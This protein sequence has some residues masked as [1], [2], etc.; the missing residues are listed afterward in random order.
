MNILKRNIIC[1]FFI[2]TINSFAQINNSEITKEEISKHLH[3]LASEELEGRGTGTPG[4]ELAAKY[5]ANELNKYGFKPV[6]D[7]GYFQYFQVTTGVLLSKENY[8]RLIDDK[9]EKEAEVKVDYTPVGFSSNG[10]IEKE[11]VFVGFGI[12]T[13]TLN[14]NDYSKVD[15]KDK[16]VVIMTGNPDGKNG[17]GKFSEY[18]SL[19]YKTSN[20]RSFGAVGIIFVTIPDSSEE[21]NL[22]RLNYEQMGGQ[23]G[24]QIVSVKYKVIN[25][26]FKSFGYD[27]K[28]IKSKIISDKVPNSFELNKIKAS[29]SVN[30]EP[31]KKWGIN[32]VGLL[33]GND[34]KL[35]NEYI[36]IGAHY[37]HLGISM[38]NSLS[39]SQK[40]EIH[41]GADDN[42]SGT[43]SVIE[44][45]QK[46]SE[47]KEE[48]KRSVIISF[49][50]GEEMGVLGSTYLVNHPPVPISNIVSMLN[51][52][53]IG[54]LKEDSVLTINGVGSSSDWRM[55][56]TEVNKKYNFKISFVN[57]ASG[58]SDHATFYG[59]SIPVLFFFTGIHSDYHKPADKPELIN[60]SGAERVTNFAYDVFNTINL[61]SEKVVFT[62]VKEDTNANRRVSLRVTAGVIP[63]F[64]E[65][66]DG[67]KISGTTEGGAAQ[68][69]G[70]KA[71][72]I[73]IKI[74][75]K[76]IKNIY[77]YMYALQL[78]K[79]GDEVEFLVKRGDQTIKFKLL[80][81]GK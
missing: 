37:D 56:L 9:N 31:E 71:N 61:R 64:E 24:C 74:G 29:I 3:Y 11:I 50:S 15:V 2:L 23:S 46:I 18:S 13:D 41:Y 14:Y 69:A 62:K 67:F 45:A 5:I 7:T 33:E 25:E 63:N 28:E 16:I 10:K 54:R 59:K 60:Y 66:A 76:D 68:K 20:A 65:G 81:I 35:K 77:D 44:L 75:D 1:I 58:G 21:D 32:V 55:L 72:D 42:A 48:L 39:Q 79:G 47:N 52:D 78:F 6:G 12:S 73:I 80:L 34:E 70:L 40:P 43:S 8:F 4:I 49:F 30:L 51:M 19:R 17:R 38:R 57:D 22:V 27:L 36:V 53:M 26:L